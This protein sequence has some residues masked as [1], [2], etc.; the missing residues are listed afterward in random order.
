MT[1]ITFILDQGIIT[2]YD[3]PN[4][5]II[6]PIP[7]DIVDFQGNT[8]QPSYIVRSVEIYPVKNN[9]KLDFHINVNIKHKR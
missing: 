5:E 4:S 2:S 8:L 7:G 1:T 6:R 3:A 9:E